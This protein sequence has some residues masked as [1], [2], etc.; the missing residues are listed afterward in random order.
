MIEILAIAF[1]LGL[2]HALDADHVVVVSSLAASR[3]TRRDALRFAMKWALGHACSFA[4]LGTGSL[5]IGVVLPEAFARATEVAA[6]L[7][8]VG[9]GAAAVWATARRGAH[10]HFHG[11]EG[12]PRHAHWHTHTPG[13]RRAHGPDDHRHDHRAVLVGLV[14]GAAGSAPALAVL[15]AAVQGSVGPATAY[16]AAFCA[17]VFVAMAVFGGLLGGVLERINRRDGRWLR[18]TRS[19]AGVSALAL[20]AFWLSRAA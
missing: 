2:L 11:H 10:L 15:P 8:L 3:P 7:A 6:G 16:L 18:A 4:A 17:G 5:L 20:G 9:V 14:H 13:S 1:G 19:L 12:L